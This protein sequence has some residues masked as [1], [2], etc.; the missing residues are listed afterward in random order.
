M[1]RTGK[2]RSVFS[3]ARHKNRLCRRP[4]TVQ[5]D[6]LTGYKLLVPC[7]ACFSAPCLVPSYAV[8]TRRDDTAGHAHRAHVYQFELFEF[9]LLLKSV[10]EAQAE[11]AAAAERRAEQLPVGQAEAAVSQSAVPYLPPCAR[12]SRGTSLAPARVRSHVGRYNSLVSRR[13]KRVQ[14][15]WRQ[16]SLRKVPQEATESPFAKPR[17]LGDSRL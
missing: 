13:A 12:T 17:V 9:V 4:K 7:L 15:E 10:A 14:R 5:G 2:L 1:L 8:F 11:R 16:G 3:V 6:S